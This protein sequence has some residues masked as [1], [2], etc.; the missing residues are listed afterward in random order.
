MPKIVDHDRCRKELM[1][2]CL[3][4]FARRGYGSIT[5]R[6]IATELGVSTGTL[7]HY[8]PS[9]ES[10]FMQLVQELC[11]QDITNFFAQAAEGG[12]LRDRLNHVITFF[13]ENFKFYQQQLLLWVDFYQHTQQKAGDDQRFLQEIWQRTHDQ[14]VTYLQLPPNRA[15]F[16][17]IFMD[18][19]LLQC[20]Y[21]RDTEKASGIEHQSQLLVDLLTE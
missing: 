17:L 7:Y 12:T 8:F 4:L 1:H 14:L 13:L 9:K 21:E 20:L 16:V 15:A 19:L 6:Q 10:L 5:M 2:K 3:A 18:G 11:E